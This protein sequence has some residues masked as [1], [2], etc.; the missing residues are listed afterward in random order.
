MRKRELTPFGKVIKI[1]LIELN[2]PQEWLIERVKERSGMYMDSSNLYK[3]MTGTVHSD[4]LEEHIR[5]AIGLKEVH[6]AV[7]DASSPKQ[8]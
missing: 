2:Q 7:L 8:A 6:E 3:I 1:K 4:V 5:E